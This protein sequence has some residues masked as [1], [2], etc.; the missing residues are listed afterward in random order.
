M[1]VRERDQMFLL[2][3][4]AGILAFVISTVLVAWSIRAGR[5]AGMLDSPGSGGHVKTLR[6]IPNI[7]GIGIFVGAVG[8]LAAGLVLLAAQSLFFN[9]DPLWTVLRDLDGRLGVL[10]VWFA[11]VIAALVLHLMGLADDRRSLGAGIKLL[12]Q[13]LL[14]AGLVLGFDVRFL[15]VLDDLGTLGWLLSVSATIAWILVITNAI[16]FLDNMDGLAA[17]VSAIAAIIM[18]VVTILNAQW[19]IAISLALL[20]G[21]LIGF[22]LFNFPPARIFMGDGGSLVIGW[23]LAVATIR[24]TFIDTADPQY[25]LGTAWYGV[26]MPLV[27]LAVPLYDFTSVVIIRTLQGR[28]PFVGDQQHFS[29]RLVARGL[30]PRNAILVIWAVALITGVSGIFL[31]SVSP[32]IAILIGIQTLLLLGVLALLE[33]GTRREREEIVRD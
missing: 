18:V 2:I 6:S 4:T 23:L 24:I 26:L 33:L 1:P 29:H 5:K 32:A 3:F 19:F 16:N 22:L 12:V 9:N 30:S 14:A 8:P 10:P 11:I 7:G 27:V 25:A 28:S 31:G 21:A 15:H 13:A 17:G 20:A